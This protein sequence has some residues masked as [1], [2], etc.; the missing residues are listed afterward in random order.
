MK[1][2]TK[3][4]IRIAIITCMILLVRCKEVPIAPPIDPNEP[5]ANAGVDQTINVG[6]YFILDGRKSTK[7]NGAKLIYKWTQDTGNP[8]QFNFFDDDSICYKTV[9]KEG[10]Y[11]YPLIVNNGIKD[12]QPALLTIQVN[13]RMNLVIADPVLEANI[14]FTLKKQTGDLTDSN[15]LS[16]DSITVLMGLYSSLKI[17]DLHGIERCQNLKRLGLT[18]QSVSDLSPLAN[19]TK[20][21]KLEVDQNFLITD[22]SPLANLTNLKYLDI[23]ANLI[24]DISLL[25]NLTNLTHF[26]IGGI[27]QYHV[28][29]LSVVANFKQL[30]VFVGSF[31][32]Q[33]DLSVFSELKELEVFYCSWSKIND[34][35]GLKNCSK[36]RGLYITA[37][38]ITDLTPITNLKDLQM[39]W[40]GGSKIEDVTPL[41]NLEKLKSV[42]LDYNLVK[43]IKPLVDNNGIGTGTTIMLRNNPLND[44][45]INEYIPQLIAR[46]VYII[47]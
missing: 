19:L 42:I 27:P 41:Q 22:I 36:L 3:L 24:T 46:G 6:S 35:T 32:T 18:L 26:L 43:D 2:F 10:V 29:N 16:L 40:V 23:S 47:R 37:N 44:K 13:P 4:F 1:T 5:V 11:K 14:R 38:E 25:T 30:M 31:L 34:L 7:G 15:F 39:L 33:P 9:T 17:A 12:S 21:E 8:E 45:S 28:T 20:L